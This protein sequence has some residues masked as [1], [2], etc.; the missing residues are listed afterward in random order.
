MRVKNLLSQFPVQVQLSEQQPATQRA[1]P[2][3]DSPLG[4]QE[5]S[6]TKTA[7]RAKEIADASAAS[8]AADQPAESQQNNILDIQPDKATI[9]PGESIDV[10]T[11]TRDTHR[12][13]HGVGDSRSPLPR[14]CDVDAPA[15]VVV[16]LRDRARASSGTSSEDRTLVVCDTRSPSMPQHI[17]VTHSRLEGNHHPSVLAA[18]AAAHPHTA[19]AAQ[20]TR[21]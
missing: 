2:R 20:S 1:S 7:L 6:P 10:R 11:S 15:Q 9:P 8:S 17:A 19:H 3:S 21:L 13:H 18:R 14:Y 5:P 12:R 4:L 16:T